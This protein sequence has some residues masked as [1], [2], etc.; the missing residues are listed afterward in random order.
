MR[1]SKMFV[2][3]LREMPSEAE[4]L[5][6]QMLLRGGF[7]RQLAAGIYAFLP[8]A[9]R[10][11]KKLRKIIREELT[12]IGAQE[13]EMP[14]LLPT[15]L[16]EQSGRLDTYGP[17]LY[18]LKDRNQR[19]Y[20]LS[21]N[22]EEAFTQLIGNDVTSYK[23][24]PLNLFQIQKK[25]RDEKRPRYGLLRSREFLM[26]DAYSFH[27]T[28]ESLDATYRDYEKAYH[29]IFQRCEL[30]FRSVLGDSGSM[31]GQDSK[32]FMALSAIGEDTL[33]YSSDSGYA[34][35]LDM[36]TALYTGRKTHVSQEPLEK[37]ATP[38]QKTIPEVA[39]FL[40]VPPERVIKS[41]LYM[42]DGEPILV[43]VRGDHEVN[44]VKLKNYLQ[45]AFLV[46][47]TE[48]EALA[49]L[50][51]PFGAIGPVGLT[52]EVKIYGDQHVRDMANAVAGANEADHHYLHVNPGRDFEAAGYADLRFVKEGEPSPD[53]QGQL[54]FAKGI[55]LG[56]ILKLGTRYTEAMDTGW[57]LDENGQEVPLQM[58]WYGIGVSRLLAAIV[59]QHANQ[60]GI[61]WPKQLAPFDLHLV[62]MNMQDEYQTRLT[63][64]LEIELESHGFDCLVD[65]R[66][67]RAGVKFAD[68]D[69]IGCPLR[70]TIGKKAI[71][72]V[73]EIKIKETG[74]MVEVRK[75]EL[76]DT[77]HI[78]TGSMA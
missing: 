38:G 58:G 55:E 18:R 17:S 44:E 63:D 5:S 24:L 3:T 29:Q 68:A 48:E 37:V 59:E 43:L 35:N 28:A 72:N 70:I 76:V 20:L 25:Y 26:K 9:E 54:I 1:Q 61:N 36:A 13:M 33:V 31:G 40:Q 66:N 73:V 45:V 2:P 77:I 71:E 47:A 57:V 62:Q 69:L 52:E 22:H 7:I 10:V 16:W 11:L 74:A 15:D 60:E 27:A 42:A 8:L 14:N 23:R 6:H 21:P 51:V 39:A 75:E 50:N 41:L 65:D 64:E 34:A 4:A 67:E 19:G 46:E 32:E 78:L 53:G 49:I 30:D 12:Q 56:H